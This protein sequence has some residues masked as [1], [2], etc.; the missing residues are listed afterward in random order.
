MLPVSYLCDIH[1]DFDVCQQLS[2]VHSTNVFCVVGAPGQF[3]ETAG[4]HSV[5]WIVLINPETIKKKNTKESSPL[6]SHKLVGLIC[7]CNKTDCN[8]NCVLLRRTMQQWH[9]MNWHPGH[10]SGGR[11][12]S[13]HS[14]QNKWGFHD[15]RLQVWREKTQ[16]QLPCCSK[17]NLVSTHS[18]WESR[19]IQ[20][21]Q[22]A[23]HQAQK[24]SSPGARECATSKGR[25]TPGS[26]QW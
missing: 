9:C 3:Q 12:G 18:P 19:C 22:T 10:S 11:T 15:M 25:W 23:L 1:L 13:A 20:R 17:Q 8:K 26:H 16:Y 4:C 21:E 5:F 24:A 14:P 7:H 6:L 2:H